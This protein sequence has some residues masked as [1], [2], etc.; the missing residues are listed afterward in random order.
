MRFSDCPTPNQNPDYAY[1]RI[2]EIFM[3]DYFHLQPI[4]KQ[5][6]PR[7]EDRTFSRASRVQGQKLKL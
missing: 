6:C 1:V 2:Q 4:K 3:F 7:A 5:C